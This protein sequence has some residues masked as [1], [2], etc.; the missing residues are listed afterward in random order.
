M[1]IVLG[2]RI[3]TQ[4]SL[5]RSLGNWL[6]LNYYPLPIFLLR[7][8]DCTCSHSSMHSVQFHQPESP[9]IASHDADVAMTTKVD[10]SMTG[11]SVGSSLLFSNS[12]GLVQTQVFSVGKIGEL[13][14]T[15][16]EVLNMHFDCWWQSLLDKNT[17]ISEQCL[18]R[19]SCNFSMEHCCANATI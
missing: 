6:S 16:I 1:K 5:D 14:E 10:G 9:L 2:V 7:S 4:P 3:S 15:T 19:V 13:L 12:Y 18:H 17:S 11:S 8:G